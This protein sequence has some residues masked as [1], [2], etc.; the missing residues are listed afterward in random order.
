[1]EEHLQKLYPEVDVCGGWAPPPTRNSP[2]AKCTLAIRELGLETF[3]ATSTLKATV[4]SLVEHEII[5]P[6]LRGAKL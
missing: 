4:D 3:T 6:L 1:M 2:R 5:E